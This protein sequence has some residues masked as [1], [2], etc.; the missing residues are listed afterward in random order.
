[1]RGLFLPVRQV[2]DEVEEDS[3]KAVARLRP[4]IRTAL[5]SRGPLNRVPFKWIQ[6][7]LPLAFARTRILDAVMLLQTQHDLEFDHQ[8]IAQFRVV[9]DPELQCL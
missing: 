9:S 4:A 1:M 5:R 7:T 6:N 3:A 2:R 8:V